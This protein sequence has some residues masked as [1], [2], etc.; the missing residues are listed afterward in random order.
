MCMYVWNFTDLR[1]AT[2]LPRNISGMQSLVMRLEERSCG[3]DNTSTGGGRMVAVGISIRVWSALHYN[4]TLYSNT[5]EGS[6]VRQ[7]C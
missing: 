5:T 1:L 6:R 4:A 7:M 2:D 3:R